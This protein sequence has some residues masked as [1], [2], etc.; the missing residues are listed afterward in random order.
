MKLCKVNPGDDVPVIFVP[1]FPVFFNVSDGIDHSVGLLLA[2][3]FTH[4]C[5]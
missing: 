3:A 5:F 4:P 1:V 2:T